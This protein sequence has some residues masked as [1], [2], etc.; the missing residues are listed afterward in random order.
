MFI[1][2]NA[3]GH[4]VLVLVMEDNTPPARGFRVKVEDTRLILVT[5]QTLSVSPERTFADEDDVVLQMESMAIPDDFLYVYI[6]NKK[7]PL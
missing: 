5:N 3:E 4:K 1:K 6:Q 7:L 2:H